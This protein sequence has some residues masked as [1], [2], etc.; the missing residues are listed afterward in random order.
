MRRL[1]PCLTVT[2][3]LLSACGRKA[4]APTEGSGRVVPTMVGT[5]IELA[6]RA[7]FSTAGG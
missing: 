6:P 2:L 5:A 4:K 7:A 1:L 3:L